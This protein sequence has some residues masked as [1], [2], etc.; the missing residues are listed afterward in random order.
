MLR[1]PLSEKDYKPSFSGHETF[2]LRYGWLKKAYDTIIKEDLSNNKTIFTDEKAVS[3]FGVGKNMV[4]SIY[5]WCLMTG[6]IEEDPNTKNLK[7]S[8]IADL[9]FSDEGDPYLEHLM[10]LWILHWN[11]ATNSKKTTLFWAFNHF[12]TQAFSRDQLVQDIINVCANQS[13]WRLPAENTLR[14]DVDC[15]V[16]T[17]S[18]LTNPKIQSFEEI[19]ES[20]LSELNIIRSMGRRDIF[21]FSRGEKS[22]LPDSVFIFSLIDFWIKFS[23][24]KTMTFEKICYEPGSPGRIFMLDEDT[25]SER[26]SRIDEASKNLFQWSETAGLKQIICESNLDYSQ[27]LQ[28]IKDGYAAKF[29]G[30]IIQ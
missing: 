26:L 25:L 19:L 3:R 9:I 21:R 27:A 4:S 24:S 22:S 14:R 13:S 12:P 23:T 10:T 5:H 16:R 28:F 18:S 20:P 1:G 6:I 7:T 2:P 29:S 11:L 8:K 30:N 17:Y 15:F